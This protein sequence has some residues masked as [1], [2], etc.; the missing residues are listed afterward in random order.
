MHQFGTGVPQDLHLAKR[1]YDS[2]LGESGSA[3]LPARFALFVL[4]A[5]RT[6]RDMAGKRAVLRR[7]EQP[8]MDVLSW[9]LHHLRRLCD[10]VYTFHAPSIPHV[11]Y[12]PGA[13]EPSDPSASLYGETVPSE[14]REG[15]G[16]SS[17]PE[18]PKDVPEK[19]A[20]EHTHSCLLYTSPSPRDQRGSRMP[21]S[22]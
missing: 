13:L 4:S 20:P 11:P 10:P 5:H 6:W 7:L 14:Q 22:A 3:W 17:E 19:D 16:Q 9:A 2:A 12:V 15:A 18:I 1:H 21:S 8:V